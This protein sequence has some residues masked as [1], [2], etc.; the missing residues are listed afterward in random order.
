MIATVRGVIAAATASGLRQKLSGSM[1]TKTGS[2]PTRRTTFAVAAN[3][4][5]GTMTSSPG[6]DAEGHAA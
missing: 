5:D 3:E 6:S 1:S 4:N 2:A